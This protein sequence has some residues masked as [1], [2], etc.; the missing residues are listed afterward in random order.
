MKTPIVVKLVLVVY[1]VFVLQYD[2]GHSFA[3]VTEDKFCGVPSPS[4]VG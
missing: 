1:Y 4:E 2:V 3:V